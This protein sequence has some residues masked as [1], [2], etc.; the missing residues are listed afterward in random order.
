MKN[1]LTTAAT[2]G[3]LL[4]S[5]AS[6]A[7][8]QNITTGI[9]ADAVVT[10]GNTSVGA[11]AS[12][13]AKV[14]ARM[15]NIVTRAGQEITRRI[16]ILNQL[17]TKVQAMVHVDANEKSSIASMVSTQ[18][19]ALQS[20]QS[21][22]SA[23]TD[24]TTLRTDVQSITQ[25]YR[26]FMLVVPQGSIAVAS[27][28]IQD[29]SQMISALSPKL[30]ARISAAQSSGANVTALSAS[31]SDMNTQTT[32]A[33]TA[34]QAA[35]SETASLM[36]DNGNASVEASNTAALKDAHSKIQAALADLK[37]ARADAGSIV[38]GLKGLD[39]SGSA[40]ASSS[41]TTQ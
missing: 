30:A 19:S 24:L 22:I 21:K 2:A 12:S 41:A 37:T 25:G 8:A 28:K 4:L 9:S 35:V 39:A 18:V 40:S 17:S 5:I 20:L 7:F 38:K 27:D 36:P 1:N 14:Q 13:S 29:V 33:T 34:A 15:Q 32:N 6:P 31:L 23:D 16:D 10:A 3:I 26:I 11:S